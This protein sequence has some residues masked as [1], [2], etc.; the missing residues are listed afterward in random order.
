MYKILV[1]DDEPI[2]ADAIGD[3]FRSLEAPEFDVCVAYSGSK[4]LEYLKDDRVSILLTDICMPRINGLELQKAALSMWPDC[5]VVFLTG[6][7]EFEYIQTAMRNKTV[8]YIL[9]TED[10]KVIIEAVRKAI[11]EIEEENN[12][13]Y[14]AEEAQK[15]F[16][17]AIPLI[18]RELA[19]DLLEGWKYPLNELDDS[20]RE[21]GIA[22]SVTQPVILAVGRVDSFKLRNSLSEK[23]KIISGIQGVMHQFLGAD[24]ANLSALYD[25]YRIVWFI[26]PQKPKEGDMA[27]CSDTQCKMAIRNIA[28]TLENIQDKCLELYKISVSFVINDM[29][30]EW[31]YLPDAYKL[32][33]FKLNC[34]FK[35]AR[36]AVLIYSNSSDNRSLTWDVCIHSDIIKSVNKVK[37]LSV[38]LEYGR[39]DKFDGVFSEIVETVG[40]DDNEACRYK[41]EI[42]YSLAAVFLAYIN[43]AGIAQ[44]LDQKLKLDKLAKL[45]VNTSWEEAMVF[46][47]RLSDAIF[48]LEEENHTEAGHKLIFEI[49]EYISENISEDISL[50]GLSRRFHFNPSYLS[51]LYKNL[52]GENLIMYMTRIKIEKAKELLADGNLKINE[53]TERLGFKTPSYF[54]NFF[55]KSTGTTPQKYRDSVISNISKN[56]ITK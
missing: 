36:Q 10:E 7:D 43:R 50:T 40:R 25:R 30:V 8:D 44:R 38:Y 21:L 53:I 51:R 31:N 16:R 6:H 41:S 56:N 35:F 33:D 27:A 22:L 11:G 47:R 52:T 12:R 26:Q 48:G 46:F 4:A 14:A 3:I 28:Y 42:Y 17:K 9:K 37:Y 15:Y 24:S 39:K 5:K 2:I 18:Q 13:K 29:P 49:Q 45:D 23:M 54:T 19:A 1:V 20:F 32:L 34:S 55:K